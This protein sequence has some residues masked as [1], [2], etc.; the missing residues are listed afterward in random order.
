[1][2]YGGIGALLTNRKTA[3]Q[4]TGLS[5]AGRNV[6][7][8]LTAVDTHTIRISLLP[9]ENAQSRSIEDDGVL[10]EQRSANPPTRFRTL[11][12][13]QSIRLGNLLGKIERDP[14]MI[15]IAD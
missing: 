4:T 3:A 14:L 12:P 5:I 15:V 6:E 2:V 13:Q 9:I 8:A 7:L 10:V 1:M 11:A